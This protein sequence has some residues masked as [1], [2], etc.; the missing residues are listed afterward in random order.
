M[1]WFPRWWRDSNRSGKR[2][3]QTASTFSRESLRNFTQLVLL[4]ISPTPKRTAVATRMALRPKQFAVATKQ[5]MLKAQSYVSS[6]SG[7]HPGLAPPLLGS[8]CFFVAVVQVSGSTGL[9]NCS[10]LSLDWALLRP[11]SQQ[12]PGNHP[13]RPARLS[14]PSRSF[15]FFRP[16]SRLCPR[17]GSL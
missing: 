16:N 5:T 3:R 13:P 11:C 10:R 8:S 15:L 6:G 9:S 12:C 2:T 14:K 1:T 17:P 4:W 7:K